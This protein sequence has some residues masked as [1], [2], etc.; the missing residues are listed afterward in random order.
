MRVVVFFDLPTIETEDRQEYAK[1]R[2]SL[3]KEGFSMVQYSVYSRICTNK[4]SAD[5]YIHKL[6]KISPNRGSVRALILTEKQYSN[7]FVI[8]GGF[9][10]S[11]ESIKDRR[12]I[13][14]WLL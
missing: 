10:V 6:Y 2:K 12:L 13:Y 8:C 9:T 4:D 3:I 5:K 7:M 14:F 1:F 11:E